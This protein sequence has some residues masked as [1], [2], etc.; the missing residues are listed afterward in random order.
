MRVATWKVLDWDAE[1]DGRL[2]LACPK[3]K[4][5]A[6]LPTSGPPGSP[7]IAAVGLSLIFD[8]AGH[9]PP[10]S[11]IPKAIQCRA[12]RNVFEAEGEHV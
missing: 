9:V 3:C 12:C 2:L 7:V 11:F 5:E 6:Y 8:K 10:D 4:R 1:P